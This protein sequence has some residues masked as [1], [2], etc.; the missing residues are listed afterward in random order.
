MTTKVTCN[1]VLKSMKKMAD[2]FIKGKP[3]SQ[4]MLEL[5]HK[6]IQVNS[7][8]M[9]T[10]VTCNLVL[11]SMK[12]MDSHTMLESDPLRQKP[13]LMPTSTD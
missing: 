3:L 13:Q 2:R 1:L 12:K 5:V 10:K 9:T 6:A 7:Q 11:K 8:P 4:E